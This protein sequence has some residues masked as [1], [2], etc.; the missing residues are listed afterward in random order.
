MEVFVYRSNKK[1]GFYLYLPKK[2]DFSAIPPTLLQALGNVEF[3]LKFEL[4]LE[5]NL[6][7]ED[8]KTVLDNLHKLGFHLQITD[9]LATPDIFKLR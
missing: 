7:K 8:P 1:A 6:A 5:R 9:P 3:S 4:H 2:D